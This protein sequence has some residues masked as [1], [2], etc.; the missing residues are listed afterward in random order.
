MHLAQTT[1]EQREKR[2]GKITDDIGKVGI[3]KT[4][5]RRKR[6]LYHSI[7]LQIQTTSQSVRQ[8]PDI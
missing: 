3:N 5:Y 2:L 1:V 4:Q 7:I 6:A 8:V